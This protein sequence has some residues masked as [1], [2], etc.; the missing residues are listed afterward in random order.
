MFCPV[1]NS[2]EKN[3]LWV[4]QDKIYDITD[5]LWE[6][7]EEN[8]NH[9]PLIITFHCIWLSPTVNYSIR[10]NSSSCFSTS[11]F[12]AYSIGINAVEQ[13]FF[14]LL[15]ISSMCI[16]PRV[17]EDFKPLNDPKPIGGL[18]VLA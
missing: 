11:S 7:E 16:L 1:K 2:H 5:E 9:W 14:Y 4:V 15:L 12:L 6:A 18:S 3:A 10:F 8:H 17:Y 13:L